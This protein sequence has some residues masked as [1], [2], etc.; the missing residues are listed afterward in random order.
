MLFG[1][2]SGDVILLSTARTTPSEVRIPI[3]VEPS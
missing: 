3:A 2:I 1:M